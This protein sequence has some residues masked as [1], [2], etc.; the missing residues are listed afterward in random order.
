MSV[1]TQHSAASIPSSLAAF[2]RR[3]R[4][5]LG[6]EDGGGWRFAFGLSAG[7]VGGLFGEITEGW[8]SPAL[9]SC[10]GL[11]L[12][13]GGVVGSA[14]GQ[15][16]MALVL[17]RDI[18]SALGLAFAAAALAAAAYRIF[19]LVPELGRGLP[20]LPSY[21]WLLGSGLLGGLVGGLAIGLIGWIGHPGLPFHLLWRWTANSLTG[22]LLVATPILL[23]A[24]R[25]LRRWMVPIVGE[26]PA[27]RPRRL[28]FAPSQI[29]LLGDE[30]MK[31]APARPRMNLRQ[32]LLMGAGLVLG[33]TAVAVPVSHLVP[34]G[35]PWVMLVYLVPILWAALGY[36]LR[37]G[38][39]A[40]S[41]S[42]VVYFLGLAWV[43]ALTGGDPGPDPW[44]QSA[45]LLILSLAGAFVGESREQEA[46]TRDE[47]M[48]ANRLLRRDVLHVAQ[49]LTQ[50]V[51]AKDS[52][53][54]GHLHR[55]SDYAVAV[56]TRIGLRGHDL[57]MLHYA[58]LLHDIGKI[59]IPE[60][61][62][63][64]QGS[65][66]EV[67]AEI[68]RR[69][70]EIGARILQKLDLLKDAAPIVMHHQERYDGMRQGAYPGYPRG[71]SGERIPLGSRIIAVVDAFDAMTTDRPYRAA[72]DLDQAVA[73]LREERG[74]QFDPFVVNVFLQIVAER[75]WQR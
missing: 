37:G 16:V 51:E 52:Y 12:G 46:R 31:L 56:G 19:C 40:G 33:V 44:M 38:A 63:R 34:E 26:L 72:L 65:L 18:A 6:L 73:V 39:L 10:S 68:M 11:L 32:A 69:H 42:G 15:L 59:G 41:A 23:V 54:E 1:L 70:P 48:D 45:H 17:H 35:A 8:V 9:S 61:V 47:L 3:L 60:D 75:G 64:K 2:G 4:E 36:G 14:I 27:R 66:D 29:E 21:L 25:S 20:N 53:T 55:V 62:L 74:R 22:T 67:E 43:A 57:E 50:A 7:L 28:S 49:A 30:T 24:D 13:W 58:G 71:L 5:L